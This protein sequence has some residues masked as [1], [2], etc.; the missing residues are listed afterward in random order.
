MSDVALAGMPDADVVRKAEAYLLTLPQVDL[1]TQHLVHG[2]VSVRTIFIPAGGH[3]TGAQ[4]NLA[5]VCIVHGDITVTTDG[6]PQRLTGFHVLP[7]NPGSK[8]YGVAH[9][10]TWWTTVHHTELTDIA[11]IENEMTDEAAMLQTR[12]AGIEYQAPVALE[13]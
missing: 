9:A 11:A 13:G 5:N 3:V 7:A 12:R 1:G 2:G 6:G 4:T 10:G 8:R